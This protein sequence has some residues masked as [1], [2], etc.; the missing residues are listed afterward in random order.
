MSYNNEGIIPLE[1]IKKILSERG[2]IKI[3]NK[4]HK[5][6]R[7]IN[8]DGTKIKTNEVLFLLKINK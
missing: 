8:Q 4:D 7:A 5:R 2:E 3:F 1:N 6:Y